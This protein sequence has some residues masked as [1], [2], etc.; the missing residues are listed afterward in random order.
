MWRKCSRRDN[1]LPALDRL[2]PTDC[3]TRARPQFHFFFARAGRMRVLRRVFVSDAGWFA[4]LLS[5]L[6]LSGCHLGP[7]P[8]STVVTVA[9]APDATS[10]LLL[11]A[12][13]V[14]QRNFEIFRRST[15]S[16]A[17]PIL[18]GSFTCTEQLGLY[19]IDRVMGGLARMRAPEDP[20]VTVARYE[21]IENLQAANRRM[22][23]DSWVQGQL[24]RYLVESGNPAAASASAANCR[25]DP[26]WWCFAL[27][28]Y[29][30]HHA[31][32]AAASEEA[33]RVALGAMPT[34]ERFHWLDIS[35]LLGPEAVAEYALLSD[36]EA[37][38]FE[39]RFWLLADPLLTRPGNEILNEHLSRLVELAFQVEAE[40]VEGPLQGR[41]ALE[42]IGRHDF[43]LRYGTPARWIRGLGSSGMVQVMSVDTVP[44]RGRNCLESTPADMVYIVQG[45]QSGEIHS[46]RGVYEAQRG[47]LPG[48]GIGLLAPPRGVRDM[49]ASYDLAPQDF[50]P[51]S[52]VLLAGVGA[53][54]EGEES[55]SWD[56]V[57][58]VPQTAYA[59]RMEGG[60]AQWI[61][62]LAH[63]LA[64]FPRGDS[65]IVVGGWDLSAHGVTASAQTDAGIAILHQDD[66]LAPAM[67]ATVDGA[68]AA[69]VLSVTVA[70]RP[71]LLSVEAVAPGELT[72]ARAR[73]GLDLAPLLPMRFAISDLLLLHGGED[74]VD[75]LDQAIGIARGSGR[76]PPGD[77]LGVY[78]EL[79]G[80]D[81]TI[82]SEVTMS[83]TLRQ[84]L[85][86][87]VGG[88]LR[89]LGETVGVLVEVAPIRTEWVEDVVSGPW[90][91]RSLNFRIPQVSEGRYTLVLSATVPGR[92]PVVAAREIEITRSIISPPTAGTL[93]RRPELTRPTPCL[94]E[95]SITASAFAVVDARDYTRTPRCMFSPDPSWFGHYGGAEHVSEYG[96]D[97]W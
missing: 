72:M 69:G 52:G 91:G 60:I 13:R 2:F 11:D 40:S 26:L 53:G 87:I 73:Y 89:W 71:S 23:E 7:R 4:L 93:V 19:C 38:R 83:L 25:A 97:G 63:Q 42:T 81:P 43:L 36:E 41:G 15:L 90:M 78:W 14:D 21:L 64:V 75:S 39:E 61:A 65:A 85:S 6:L 59:I 51:P 74:E 28:G 79:Y 57:H 45:A 37:V 80:L 49:I 9:A 66:L 32:L 31:G 5:C 62:P 46:V 95:T 96:Y 86:G 27:A 18:S 1:I 82:S 55:E 44:C 58:E 35:P 50:L 68:T 88:A 33:F 34:E 47:S 20:A 56:R 92:E 67:I 48:P 77:L 10:L 3:W 22:P 12:A 8:T 30:Y 84:P 94:P 24:I 16:V 29:V 76:A 17:L 54:G 70:A